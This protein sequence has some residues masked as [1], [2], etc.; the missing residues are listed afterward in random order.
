MNINDAVLSDLLKCTGLGRIRA[1]AIIRYREAHGEYQHLSDVAL[2]DGIDKQTVK[3]LER[4]G[5]SANDTRQEHRDMPKHPRDETI[6]RIE[7]DIITAVSELKDAP[8]NIAAMLAA[9]EYLLGLKLA[10]AIADPK[11]RRTRRKRTGLPA[12]EQAS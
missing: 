10:D 7:Q 8:S 1:S 6:A 9:R 3:W 12:E 11:P 4:A 2:V 5:Y